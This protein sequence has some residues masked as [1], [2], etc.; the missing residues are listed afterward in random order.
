MRTIEAESAKKKR[1]AERAATAEAVAAIVQQPEL[2]HDVE[3][4]AG[5]EADAT[6]HKPHVT[7]DMHSFTTATVVF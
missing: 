4:S 6:E 2:P 1:K 5:A 7:Y 3:H